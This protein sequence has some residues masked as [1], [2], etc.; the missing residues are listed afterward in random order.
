MF[1]KI[2]NNEEVESPGMKYRHYAP[3]A[4]CVLVCG[5]K[6]IDKINELVTKKA[7]VI[8]NEENKLKINTN[9]F[10]SYGKTLEDISK[11]IFTLLRKVDLLNPEL[12]I[13]EGVEKQ[14]LRNSYN[15]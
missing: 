14:G 3:T 6:K 8:G 2:D 10:F 9:N 15:E 13:V 5:D 12:I 1:S 4:K 7:I 11:N